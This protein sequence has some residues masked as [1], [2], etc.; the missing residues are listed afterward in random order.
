MSHCEM[1]LYENAKF[2]SQG[3]KKYNETRLIYNKVKFAK[4]LNVII[5]FK[6]I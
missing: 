4:L 2:F 5:L 1:H 6:L 3:F